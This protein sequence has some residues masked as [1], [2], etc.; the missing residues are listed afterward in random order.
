MMHLSLS[1]KHIFIIM[2]FVLGGGVF[3][4]FFFQKSAYALPNNAPF[5]TIED[6]S[7]DVTDSSALIAREKALEEAQKKALYTLLERLS[8]RPFSFWEISLKSLTEEDLSQ[9]IA[10]FETTQEKSSPLR[11]VATLTYRFKKKGIDALLL[12]EGLEA[13]NTITEPVLIIPLLKV[14]NKIYL[15][16]EENL[17]RHLWQDGSL[18]S[19]N[20]PLLVPLGDLEDIQ[21]IDTSQALEENFMALNAISDRYKATGG[22]VVVLAELHPDS[23]SPSLKEGIP[24]KSSLVDI[25]ISGGL[26]SFEGPW[27]PLTISS[28]PQESTK[29]LLD[30]A[31]RE[32][33]KSLNTAWSRNVLDL[34][35]GKQDLF[36][37]TEFSSQREWFSIREALTNLKNHH[38]ILNYSI[39]KLTPH[40]VSLVLNFR[41]DITTLISRFKEEHLDLTN[42]EGI[43]TLK[44]AFDNKVPSISSTTSML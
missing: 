8:G 29:N 19:S 6:I 31:L 12:K 30:R 4:S 3:N 41:G 18:S 34:T 39:Q 22:A 15:W 43:W 10:D 23:S 26:P 21:S 20:I 35:M 13:Q 27:Q 24:L 11:Y 37:K 9:L 40:S 36:V 38:L 44:R 33:I 25:L 16:E 5:Y 2:I 32:V 7:V 14:H 1:S 42:N 17:W 28:E